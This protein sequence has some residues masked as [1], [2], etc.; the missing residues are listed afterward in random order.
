MAFNTA[1]GGKAADTDALEDIYI[2]NNE[3]IHDVKS[4]STGEIGAPAPSRHAVSEDRPE[5]DAST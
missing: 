3:G 1:P 2:Y 5:T 4:D